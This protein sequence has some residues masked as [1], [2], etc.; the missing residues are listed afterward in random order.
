MMT[1][2]ACTLTT[3]GEDQA[4][5]L[6]PQRFLARQPILDGRR[7]VM[8]YELL[9]RTGWENCFSGEREQAARQTLDNYLCMGIESLANNGLAFVNCTREALVGKWVTLLPPKTVVLEVLE[10][11]APDADLVQACA[12]LCKMGYRIALDDFEPRPEMQPLVEL[13]SYIKVD[14]RASD[15]ATRR[16]IRD[17]VRSSP[18]ALLAEKVESQEDFDVARDEGYKY[19]QGYFFCYPKIMFNREV[20]ANRINYLR[21][22]VELTRKELNLGEVAK[23]VQLEASLT[24]RLLLLANS[25]RW[26]R[27]DDVKSIQEAFM[28]VGE[29]RFR[30]LV[31]VAASCVLSQNQPPALASLSLERARFCELVA[32]LVGEDPG[33]QFMLG[34]MSLLDATLETPMEA[35]VQSLPLRPEAKAALTGKGDGSPVGVPLGLIRGFESGAWGS[36]SGIAA[37]LGISEETLA[38]KYVESVRWASESLSWSK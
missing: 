30:A 9:F 19:F 29:N 5:A 24:Y 8:G 36:C 4:S 32:P 27:R 35:V 38:M 21:L 16:Q 10:T 1:E 18:A 20:P 15:A 7:E 11:V 28:V 25:A 3:T 31:S 34:L 6:H 2:E 37:K 22:L 23:I 26:S 13:A 33:E 17:A 14:L 12:D